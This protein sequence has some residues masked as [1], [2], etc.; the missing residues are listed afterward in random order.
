MKIV[1]VLVM[2]LMLVF[3]WLFATSLIV[4]GENNRTA[5]KYKSLFYWF[6]VTLSFFVGYYLNK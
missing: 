6:A 2:V 3:C 1:L 5:F 4:N